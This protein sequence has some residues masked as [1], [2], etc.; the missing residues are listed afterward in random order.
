MIDRLIAQNCRIFQQQF[1]HAG[2]PVIVRGIQPYFFWDPDTLK[3]ATIDTKGLFGRDK[4]GNK[5]KIRDPRPLK[6]C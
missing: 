2:K 6:V 4:Q 3:R 1:C 5:I